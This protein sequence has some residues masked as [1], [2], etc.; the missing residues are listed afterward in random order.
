MDCKHRTRP[1]GIRRPNR[2]GVRIRQK[3]IRK[4]NGR[5]EHAHEERRQQRTRERIPKEGPLLCRTLASHRTRREPRQR[6]GG[7]PPRPGNRSG[8][9]KEGR[10]FVGRYNLQQRRNQEAEE[11]GTTINGIFLCI[12]TQK[13]SERD[14]QNNAKKAPLARVVQFKNEKRG[15]IPPKR[16]VSK[17]KKNTKEGGL[18]AWQIIRSA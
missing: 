1:K 14:H 11:E 10:T 6:R 9:R 2:D 13:P 8:S 16:N 12:T 5:A 18:T 3:G 7:H 15:T 17:I 4:P